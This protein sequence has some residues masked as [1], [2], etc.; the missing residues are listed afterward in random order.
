MS[1]CGS[2]AVNGKLVVVLAQAA[3]HVVGVVAQRVLLAEHGDM[4]VCA[5]HRRA[6]EV[7]RAGVQT[8][9]LLIGVL[10]VDAL[11]QRERRR[12]RG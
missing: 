8:G 5:V 2:I 10:L 6:H 1:I 4:V 3:G 9:I 7:G 12:G 11:W